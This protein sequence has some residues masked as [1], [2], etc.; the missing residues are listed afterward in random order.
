MKRRM[1]YQYQERGVDLGSELFLSTPSKLAESVLFYLHRCGRFICTTEYRIIRENFNN[2]LIFYVDQGSMHIENEG[3]TYTA[4]KGDVGIINCHI[5]HSYIALEDQTIFTWFHFSGSNTQAIYEHIIERHQAVFSVAEDSS[6]CKNLH[7]LIDYYREK[8]QEGQGIVPEDHVAKCVHDILIGMLF[9]A[10]E[11]GHTVNPS[12]NPVI[13]SSVRYI[14][15][16][17]MEPIEVNDV[18]DAVNISRFHFSRM[19]KQEVGYTP[20]EYIVLFRIN[21]AKDLLKSTDY[22]IAEIAAR[23]GYEYSTSFTSVFQRKVGV[24]PKKYRDMLI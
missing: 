18:A 6:I 17:Y 7:L 11:S 10:K 20:H 12:R 15:E 19:F 2:Y 5:P 24:T 3:R 8:E 9:V 21:R 22:S 16:H 13:E 23:V 1:L 4:H 14:R